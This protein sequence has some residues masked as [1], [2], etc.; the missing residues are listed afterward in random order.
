[1]RIF[2][3]AALSAIAG[4]GALG[5]AA[6]VAS[7]AGAA[8]SGHHVARPTAITN[9]SYY[10]ALG[11]SLAAGYQPGKGDN[12]T[13]GYV[14]GVYHALFAKQHNMNLIN[15]ACSGETSASFSADSK[16]DYGKTYGR[17][18]LKAALGTLAAHKGQV[19]VVTLDVGANDVQTCVTHTGSI[20][21]GCLGAG[22]VGVAQN[23]PKITAQIRAAAPNARIVLLNY[24]NPFLATYLQGGQSETTAKLSTGLQAVLN[25]EITYGALVAKAQVADIATAFDS[26]DWFHETT[27][28]TYGT[29]P[30]NVA[31]ICTKTWMCAKSDIHANDTGYALMAAT[32]NK[33]LS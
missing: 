28:P 1:M 18:Q 5:L 25:A 16:C 3:R 14:G 30:T 2:A 6:T 9:A 32:V 29:L 19:K 12:K 26:Y 22:L 27:V 17:S 4:A 33:T 20:D 11:D 8:P 10:V 13:G 23:L 21:Y 15:L 24:Y 31:A 7:P